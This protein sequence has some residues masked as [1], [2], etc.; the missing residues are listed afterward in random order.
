MTFRRWRAVLFVV[1][2]GGLFA[3]PAYAEWLFTIVGD[4][5][6]DYRRAQVFPEMVKE[7]NQTVW[8]IKDQEVRPEFLLHLGDFEYRRGGRESLERAKDRLSRLNMK[9]YVARGNYELVEQR[10]SF[11][12]LPSIHK[13]L[14]DNQDFVREYLSF[15]DLKET[16][17]SFDQRDL[18]VVVLDNSIGTFQVKSGEEVRSEQLA[19]LA[20]DLEE[21]ARKV[22]AGQIHHTIV[23]AHMPL[24]SPSPGITTHDMLEYVSKHYAEGR[25]L[26]DESAKIFWE[27]LEKNKEKSRISRLF[28][29]HDHRYV[30]YQQRGFPVTITAGGGAPLVE[31]EKGGFYHYLQIL[32]SEQDIRERIIKVFPPSKKATRD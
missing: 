7:I 27:I 11:F 22:Q 9:A 24:P 18:H 19:W 4:S 16:Y 8:K 1:L 28:F 2:L 20:R 21:T 23:C 15:F 30:S 25:V 29:S 5:R 31:E 3:A 26:A 17:Y 6:E 12:K 32:V 10:G 14:K 13:V